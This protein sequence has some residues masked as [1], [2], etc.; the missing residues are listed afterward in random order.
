MEE[1]QSTEKTADLHQNDE[2]LPTFPPRRE[3]AEHRRAKPLRIPCSC[4]VLAAPGEA[5]TALCATATRRRF[6][7]K[8]GKSIFFILSVKKKTLH[9]PLFFHTSIQKMNV[10]AAQIVVGLPAFFRAKKLIFVL[11]RACMGVAEW[12]VRV[13]GHTQ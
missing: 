12:R 3:G 6:S 5:S 10:S 8:R 2:A 4:G 9:L 13:C 7:T 11:L 1:V